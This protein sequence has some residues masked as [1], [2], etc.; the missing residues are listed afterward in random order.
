MVKGLKIVNIF[1]EVA[2]TVFHCVS[3]LT[4]DNGMILEN[5]CRNGLVIS[6]KSVGNI[7]IW[8]GLDF[9]LLS[10]LGDNV[11]RGIHAA[12]EIALS[13][14]KIALVMNGS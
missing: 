9:L 10:E 4:V 5:F 3:V 14:V 11:F 7:V 6:R 8:S 13:E 2:E 12:Y 1:L